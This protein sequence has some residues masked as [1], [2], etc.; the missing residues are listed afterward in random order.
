MNC[1]AITTKHHILLLLYLLYYKTLGNLTWERMFSELIVRST[2]YDM[3][4][5]SAWHG[6]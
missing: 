1:V 6:E 3:S 4:A 5:D 2:K